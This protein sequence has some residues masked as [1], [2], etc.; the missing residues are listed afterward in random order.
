MSSEPDPD[1]Y[2]AW[3]AAKLW[4][5]LPALYRA[6]DSEEIDGKGPLKEMVGRIGAQAAIVRRSI[7]RL[8]MG[9]VA[10]RVVRLAPCHVLTVHHPERDCLAGESIL[11]TAVV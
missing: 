7:D 8:S 11:T 2:D 9:S 4:G 10:E 5:L 3:Y 1:R 6:E